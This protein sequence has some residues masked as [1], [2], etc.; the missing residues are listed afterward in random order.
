MSA[1]KSLGFSNGVRHENV[2][3]PN[4]N[5]GKTKKPRREAG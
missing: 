5:R 2:N 3:L 1:K 4:P